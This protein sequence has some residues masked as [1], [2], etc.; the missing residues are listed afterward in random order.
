MSN[1]TRDVPQE[2]KRAYEPPQLTVWGSILELTHGKKS[3]PG[4]FP[5][6]GTVPF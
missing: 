1:T 3:F 4:D 2:S 6:G 5:K